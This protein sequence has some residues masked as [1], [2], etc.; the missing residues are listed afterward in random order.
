M[1]DLLTAIEKCYSDVPKANTIVHMYDIKSWLSAHLLKLHNHSHP[2]IF[3]F[4]TGESGEVVMHYKEWSECSWEPHDN[5]IKLFKVKPG[6][7]MSHHAPCIMCHTYVCVVH[8]MHEHCNSL[9]T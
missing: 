3:R 2:H 4:T 9:N 1:T 8:N 5:G 7:C 6:T